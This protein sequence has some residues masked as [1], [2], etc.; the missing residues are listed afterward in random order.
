MRFR[1]KQRREQKGGGK[2]WH[3]QFAKGKRWLSVRFVTERVEKTGV[4]GLDGTHVNI[5]KEQVRSSAVVRKSFEI[6]TSKNYYQT[7]KQ[8]QP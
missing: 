8:I 3:A 4:L 6:I 5:A 1:L 2:L 7:F